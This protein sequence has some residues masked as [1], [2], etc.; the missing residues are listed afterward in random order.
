MLKMET[1]FKNFKTEFLP[2]EVWKNGPPIMWQKMKIMLAG[3]LIAQMKRLDALITTQ[4]KPQL[5][6]KSYFWKNQEKTQKMGIFEKN[7][8]FGEFS[9]FFQK[10]D[11]AESW[12]FCVVISASKRFI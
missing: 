8:I 5:S 7:V 3:C 6:A 12:G 4:K 10:W 1:I 9:R 2:P 11:F